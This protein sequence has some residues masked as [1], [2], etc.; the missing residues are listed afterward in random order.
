MKVEVSKSADKDIEK[1]TESD[2]LVVL[3]Q[4][5]LLME[6]ATL[7]SMGNVEKIK[8]KKKPV[9]YRLKI[10]NYRI[11]IEKADTEIDKLLSI[12]KII[13]RSISHRKDAYKKR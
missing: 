1:L 3:E 12:H 11:M 7:G 8:G 6:A 9:L 13:I 5:K 10:D 4:L 2:R